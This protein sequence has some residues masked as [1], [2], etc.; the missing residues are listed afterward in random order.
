MTIS[1]SAELAACRFYQLPG[2]R[3]CNFLHGTDLGVKGVP[4]FLVWQY[5]A[6]IVLLGSD[7]GRVFVF[8]G[9]GE[10]KV[11]FL[12]RSIEFFV[13]LEQDQRYLVGFVGGQHFAVEATQ[14]KFELEIL[15]LWQAGNVIALEFLVHFP[16]EYRP[17][18]LDA[19]GQRELGGARTAVSPVESVG[20]VVADLEA[21]FGVED[22]AVEPGVVPV[23]GLV[24]PV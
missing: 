11:L 22:I 16:G 17:V 5:G 18:Q 24:V 8:C 6:P 14:V 4:N 9:N 13:S 12:Q 21:C 19:D 1:L 7:D 20:A 10:L 2:R 23:A 3:V 15:P